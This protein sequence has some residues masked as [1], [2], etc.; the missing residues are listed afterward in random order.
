MA[1][2]G[3]GFGGAVAGRGGSRVK[4]IQGVLDWFSGGPDGYMT[5]VHCFNHD[6]LWIWI[7]VA[8]NVAV[9]A[10]MVLGE[11]LRQLR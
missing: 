4:S 5:L 10:A 2:G 1:S 8:L 6:Y 11:A 7:T 9:A 3:H